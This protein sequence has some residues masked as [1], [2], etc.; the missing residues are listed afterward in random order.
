MSETER[1]DS[2]VIEEFCKYLPR[3]FM[4]DA[5]LIPQAFLLTELGIEVDVFEKIVKLENMSLCMRN[6]FGIDIPVVN[7]SGKT[8]IETAQCRKI[9]ESIYWYD[10]QLNE[11]AQ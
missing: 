7:R 9:I 6:Q 4:R 1:E 11:I 5:H 8:L 10:I 3:F 2:A